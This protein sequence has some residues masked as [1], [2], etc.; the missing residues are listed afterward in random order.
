M[1]ISGAE[2][3]DGWANGRCTVEDML[4]WDRG[5]VIENRFSD[6]VWALLQKGKNMIP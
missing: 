1:Y 6:G 5:G 2:I 3:T 4:M